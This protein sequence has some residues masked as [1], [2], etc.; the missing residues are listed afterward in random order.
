M[1]YTYNNMRLKIEAALIKGKLGEM[2]G[3]IPS[4]DEV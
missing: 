3:G 4:G 1:R 2:I